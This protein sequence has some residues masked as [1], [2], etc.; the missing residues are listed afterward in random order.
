MHTIDSETT[1]TKK[2]D[3]QPYMTHARFTRDT[4]SYPH[5]LTVEFGLNSPNVKSIDTT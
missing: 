4:L 5:Q 1:F 2:I 3:M